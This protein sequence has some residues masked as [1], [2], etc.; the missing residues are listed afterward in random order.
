M[1]V[2]RFLA[3]GNVWSYACCVIDTIPSIWSIAGGS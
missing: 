2:N 3:C 1:N